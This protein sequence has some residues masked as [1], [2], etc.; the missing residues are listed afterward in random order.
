MKMRLIILAVGSNAYYLN[1]HL[2]KR[3]WAIIFGAAS[4]S[5]DLLPTLH[6]FRI[7]SFVGALTTTYTA[8]YMLTAA[9][10]RGQVLLSLLT[11]KHIYMPVSDHKIVVFYDGI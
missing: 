9:L 7:F 3:T 2:N 1:P 5:V 8:W 10:V 6:N 4:L 11:W